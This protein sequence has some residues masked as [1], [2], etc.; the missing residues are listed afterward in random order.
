MQILLLPLFFFLP[1]DIHSNKQDAGNHEIYGPLPAHVH[2]LFF[3]VSDK[4]SDIRENTHPDTGTESSVKTE[5]HE[6]H[7]AQPC[8]K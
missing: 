1:K 5:F 4:I 8:G 7:S 2:D 3:V 6:V